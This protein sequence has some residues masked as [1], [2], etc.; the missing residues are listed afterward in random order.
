MLFKQLYFF[1]TSQ[2]LSDFSLLHKNT[3]PGYFFGGPLV[4]TPKSF[5]CKESRFDS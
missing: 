5:Q 1:S 4:K 2:D 3:L